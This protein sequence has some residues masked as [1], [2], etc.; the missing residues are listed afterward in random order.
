MAETIKEM[1]EKA[2]AAQEAIKDY[3]QEQVDKLVY[4]AG[5]IIYDH[6]RE[7]AVMAVEET[8]L[9]DIEEKVLKNEE[10]GAVMWEYL[11]DKKSVG[12]LDTKPD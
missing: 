10:T 11:K 3:T 2:R 12:L 8:G 1:I 4:E 7:L 6:A 9:G 5:K